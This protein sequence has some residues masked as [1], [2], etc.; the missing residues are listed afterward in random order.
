MNKALALLLVPGLFAAAPM[1]K[2]QEQATKFEAYGGYYYA[3]I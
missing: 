1:M 2:A 3:R